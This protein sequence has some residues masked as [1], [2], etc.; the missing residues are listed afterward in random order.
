VTELAR[1]FGTH[2]ARFGLPAGPAMVGVSGGVDSLALLDLLSRAAGPL[3]LA[4]AVLH[5]DHGIDPASAE[6]A[7]RVRAVAALY[8]LPCVVERLSLGAGATETGARRE[9][10]RAFRVALAREECRLLFLAHQADDQAETV[11]MRLLRGSGPAGLAG[12]PERRGPFVRPLLP[13]RRT[14]LERHVSN[15]GLEAWSDPA[16]RDARHLR[17]W[18]RHDVMPVLAARIPD[19]VANLGRSARLAGEDRRAWQS[20]V[21][22][23]PEVDFRVDQGVAS[24]AAVPLKGYSSALRRAILR[25]L[26]RRVGVSLGGSA[27]DRVEALAGEGHT[28]QVLELAAGGRA[29]YAFGRIRLFHFTGHPEVGETALTGERGSLSLGPWR[30]SWSPDRGPAT[31]DR[32]GMTTWVSPEAVLSLRGWRPGDRIRP[33]GG[34]GSRLVVRCMQDAK[35]ARSRRPG[36]PVV[37]QGGRVLWVPGVCRSDA[38]VPEPKGDALRIDARAI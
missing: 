24:V 38:L 31:L 16:N 19:L 17:A 1:R 13:F 37:E 22:S 35:V 4:L 32:G 27:L 15:L 2:L 9:R 21:K 8:R 14:E 5:V 36:W 10:Y 11:L 12:I 3:G 29:E 26:A 6:V 23:L 34:S 25:A 33:L 30:L 18:V 20:V 7:E 28:G